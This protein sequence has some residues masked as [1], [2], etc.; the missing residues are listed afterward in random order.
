MKPNDRPG[1]RSARADRQPGQHAGAIVRAARL[2]GGLTLAQLG[3][4]CGYSASQISRY[5]RGVQ[6]LTDI[7]LLRRFA[8]EL[9][10]PPQILGLTPMDGTGTGRH[11]GDLKEHDADTCR[12]NVSH[13]FQVEGGEDPVPRKVRVLLG[14]ML[15]HLILLVVPSERYHVRLGGC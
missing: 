14:A 13:E 9:A 2:A 12:P 11:A 3:Q 10:I 8:A 1:F 4:R 5:E 15:R 6:P 7:I